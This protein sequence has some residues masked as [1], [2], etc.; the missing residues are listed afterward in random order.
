MSIEMSLEKTYTIQQTSSL[1]GLSAGML[2]YY[3][4]IGLIEPIQRGSRSKHRQYSDHD[5]EVAVVISCLHAVGMN[6]RN[7]RQFLENRIHGATTASKQITL[8]QTQQSYLADERLYLEL[9]EKYLTIKINYYVALSVHNLD[10]ANKLLEQ[11]RT[12]S[13]QVRLH[14]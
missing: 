2:R 3:E 9:R 12:T 5:I 4:S 10:E 7:M 1:S 6:T 11:I 8:L 13:K 14:K